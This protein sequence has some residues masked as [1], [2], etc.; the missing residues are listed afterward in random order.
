VPELIDV[1]DLHVGDCVVLCR[2]DEYWTWPGIVHVAGTEGGADHC[3]ATGYALGHMIG[4]GCI[5]QVGEGPHTPYATITILTTRP[6]GPR[7][8][9]WDR[10]RL[11]S[12]GS[13]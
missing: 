5:V 4:D 6:A 10:S 7:R 2:S 9:R 3:F 11:P 1:T 8:G 13:M 12:G